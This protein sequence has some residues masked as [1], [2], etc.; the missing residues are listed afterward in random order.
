M[1]AIT[2]LTE[3]P[4]SQ[5]SEV[6][7]DVGNDGRDRPRGRADDPS[8]VVDR[9]HRTLLATPPDTSGDAA[10]HHPTRDALSESASHRTTPQ[11]RTSLAVAA[12]AGI[13]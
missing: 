13:G 2:G 1:A 11:P 3:T 9:G 5:R 12:L 4:G 10:G 8:P 7:D 6:R